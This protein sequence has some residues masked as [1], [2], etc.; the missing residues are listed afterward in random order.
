M[1][2]RGLFVGAMRE[3]ISLL[4]SESTKDAANQT[5]NAWV[6]Y[7][8]DIPA[9]M[10]VVTGGET[11]RGRQVEAGVSVIFTIRTQDF[12]VGAKTHQ[13]R[14]Q[15]T[16]KDYGIVSVEQADHQGR[17]IN[18]KCKRSAND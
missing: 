14:H 4:V 7:C 3:R 16:S 10:E 15:D 2:P 1:R 8:D 18:L 6:P 5:I 12:V 17:Y 13:V 11:V 9:A